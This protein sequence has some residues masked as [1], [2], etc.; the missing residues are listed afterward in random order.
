M[1]TLIAIGTGAAYLF[2]LFAFLMP[3]VF[4]EA[5]RGETVAIGLYFEAAAVIVTL[6]SSG[7]SD[8]TSRSEPNRRSAPHVA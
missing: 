1:F 3:G 6:S 8:G 2:S 7:T 5:L 4:P